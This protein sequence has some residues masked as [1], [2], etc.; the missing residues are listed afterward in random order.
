[1]FIKYDVMWSK[2]DISYISNG[3]NIPYLGL[4]TREEC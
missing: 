2:D 3:E 4:K 1:M